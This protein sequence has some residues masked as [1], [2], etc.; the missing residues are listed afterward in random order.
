MIRIVLYIVG[1]CDPFSFIMVDLLLMNE[2]RE[3]RLI[4]GQGILAFTA[5]TDALY[6]KL[7]RRSSFPSFLPC[8][9]HVFLVTTFFL[10]GK[11]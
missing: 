3:V 4:L 9:N 6:G 8:F 10:P 11:P 2:L 7:F 1:Y 5:C